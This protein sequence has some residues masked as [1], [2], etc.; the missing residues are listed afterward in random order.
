MLNVD[1][2]APVNIPVNWQSELV[3]CNEQRC[4]LLKKLLSGWDGVGVESC[5]WPMGYGSLAHDNLPVLFQPVAV[6]RFSALESEKDVL[7]AGLYVYDSCLAILH[8]TLSVSTAF[9]SIDDLAISQ[10]VEALASRH[11]SPLMKHIYAQKTES[12]LIQ[13]GEYRFFAHSP[14]ELCN[15]EP[16]WV[17]RM[18]TLPEQEDA[19]KYHDWLKSIDSE[20]DYLL[21]GS[22]NSLLLSEEYYGDVHRIM[23]MAQFHAALMGC[24]EDVLKDNLRDINGNY[25]NK[26]PRMADGSSTYQQY[27]TDH[28]EFIKIQMS[29]A[30]A[31]VQGRRRELLRQ[32]HRAWGSDEQHERVDKLSSLTQ[33]RLDRMLQEKLGRQ[34]RSIQTLLA[35]LGSLGMVSLVTDLIGVNAAV[36]HEHTLG[37]LDIVQQ[38][39]AEHLIGFTVIIVFVFTLYFYKNHE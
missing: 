30:T 21:L 13:P 15:C 5:N 2:Y 17:A 35:F 23:V 32:F 16:L 8:M 31:G 28:I 38:F 29:S 10:R 34:N 12:P 37:V 9:P 4:D 24:V 11:L 7:A 14:E 26:K 1:I 6:L 3:D 39:S 36:E 20:S 19:E 27:R 18:L 25:Y 22:G 33:T